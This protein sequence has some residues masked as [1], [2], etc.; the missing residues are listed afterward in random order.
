[1]NR[2]ARTH[3]AVSANLVWFVAACSTGSSTPCQPSSEHDC[4]STRSDAGEAEAGAPN[5]GTLFD[6]GSLV[7]ICEEGAACTAG[8][9]CATEQNGVSVTL[10]CCAGEYLGPC[11]DGGPLSCPASMPSGACSAPDWGGTR[12]DYTPADGGAI[13]TCFCALGDSSAWRCGQLI[14]E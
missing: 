13:I 6:A 3:G 11:R 14:T 1:M 12:C 10:G 2:R 9:T 4:A 7:P 8:Q 5:L